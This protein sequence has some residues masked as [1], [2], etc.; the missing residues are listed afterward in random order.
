MFRSRHLRF[1]IGISLAVI[2]VI[3][4]FALIVFQPSG[5]KA[6][7]PLPMAS[8]AGNSSA[9]VAMLIDGPVN[10]VSLHNQVQVV[11][12]NSATTFNIFSGYDDNLVL[13]HSYP[14]SVASFHVF[15]RS[16]EYAN[17]N[18]GSNNPALSQASGYCPTGDRYIFSFD[19]NNSQVER[20]WATNCG[21]THTYDGNLNLTLTLFEA[22]VPNFQEMTNS[23]NL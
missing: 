3:V 17:F 21:G 6:K 9:Q 16:L 1:I 19:V 11:V 4:L 23:L 14:M 12:S 2:L 15:L 22:Q 5:P 7:I 13:T 20:Y 10:A 8:Y 18:S